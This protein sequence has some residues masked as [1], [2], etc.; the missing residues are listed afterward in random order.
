MALTA[1]H[2]RA[3]LRD[4]TTQGAKAG[5]TR[6]F[7]STAAAQVAAPVIRRSPIEEDNRWYDPF[8]ETLDF[9]SQPYYGQMNVFINAADALRGKPF[10]DPWTAFKSG[11][12]ENKTRNTMSDVLEASGVPEGW[13]WEDAPIFGRISSLREVRWNSFQP[14]FFV[15]FAR[16]VL[17]QAPQTML[18]SLPPLAEAKRER[19][20]ASIVSRFPNISV[21]DVTGSQGQS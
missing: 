3:Y 5:A 18:A 14:N 2:A 8:L 9:I 19:L 16:G 20:Q 10:T 11:F 1:A 17:E 13:V 15:S 6:G 7:P 21:I 4:I 12:G